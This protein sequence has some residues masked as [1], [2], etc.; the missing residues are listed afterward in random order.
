MTRRNPRGALGVRARSSM[1]IVAKNER[2]LLKIRILTIMLA[3]LNVF[4]GILLQNW[5]A[6][7]GWGFGVFYAVLYAFEGWE[8]DG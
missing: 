5:A 8:K 2:I 4:A 6:V 1:L 7:L 3:S